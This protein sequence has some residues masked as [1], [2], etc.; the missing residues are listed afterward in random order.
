MPIVP[1]WELARPSRV[2]NRA[3][4]RLGESGQRGTRSRLTT[5][6]TSGSLRLRS[7]ADARAAHRQR[8]LAA[9]RVLPDLSLSANRR[10]GG[11]RDGTKFGGGAAE[12]IGRGDAARCSLRRRSQRSLTS[13]A[14]HSASRQ[15]TSDTTSRSCPRFR[16]AYTSSAAT[17][18]RPW[19]A[20]TSAAGRAPR[21]QPA[22]T[23]PRLARSARAPRSRRGPARAAAHS[24]PSA[25][26]STATCRS[27]ASLS[28]V[29]SRSAAA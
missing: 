8:E 25:R 10:G 29:A 14:S 15:S 5:Q 28:I 22:R 1:S 18:H 20:A 27:G 17:V 19:P 24:A 9:R 2:G 11:G 4:A 13:G 3:Q 26:A 23:R 12:D 6:S 21:P 7:R 16:C